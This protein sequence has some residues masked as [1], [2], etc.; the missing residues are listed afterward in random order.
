MP[1]VHG[2]CPRQ[3]NGQLRVEVTVF[4]EVYPLHNIESL[5]FL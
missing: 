5:Y 3:L 1:A 2:H 4:D